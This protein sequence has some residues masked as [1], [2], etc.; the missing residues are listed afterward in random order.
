MNPEQT[1]RKYSYVPVAVL[2][3]I[4]WGSAIPFINV[5]YRLFDISSAGISSLILFAIYS[6]IV[7]FTPPVSRFHPKNSQLCSSGADTKSLRPL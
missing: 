7:I 6:C 1:K 2:C 5:G 4:L 3:N